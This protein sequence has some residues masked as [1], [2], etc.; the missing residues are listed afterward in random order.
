MN[1][2]ALPAEARLLPELE[3]RARAAGNLAELGFSI[4]NDSYG[5]LPFRQALVFSGSGDDS[6]L[7]CVSGLAKATEDSPYLVWLRRTWPWLQRRFAAGAAWCAYS[8]LEDAPAD[9]L[10][11]WREWWPAGVFTSLPAGKCRR[12]VSAS[13]ARLL[14]RVSRSRASRRSG[15]LSRR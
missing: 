8:E 4:A 14:A 15:R 12:T 3:A 13:R 9:V 5:L 11:G 1:G 6:R 10:E 2:A 7:L